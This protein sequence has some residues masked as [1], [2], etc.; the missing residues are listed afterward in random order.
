MP[1]RNADRLAESFHAQT[2]M[3]ATAGERLPGPAPADATVVALPRIAPDPGLSVE[4][5]IALRR[6]SRDFDPGRW[7]PLDAVAR[8]LV[9]SCGET[10]DDVDGALAGCHRAVPSAGACYPVD[11]HVIAQR[12]AGLSP[13]AYAYTAT[14]HSLALR[15]AGRFDASVARWA[16]DQPWMARAAVV[17]ALVGTLARIK[18]RY[19]ARGYRYMLMEAGHIAQNLYLLATARGLCVQAAGGFF[20]AAFARLLALDADERALYLVGVGP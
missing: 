4:E 11:V 14:D 6:T 2:A 12:V 15:R 17:F 19:A 9:L 13:G 18:P 20:D 7:L 3:L 10:A 16:L 1:T 5:A 8:L